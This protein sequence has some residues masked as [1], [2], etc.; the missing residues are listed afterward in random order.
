MNIT[1]YNFIYF[2]VKLYYFCP[3]LN[4]QWFKQILNDCKT[5]S[6]D[7]STTY[8]DDMLKLRRIARVFSKI[9]NL[10]CKA[11]ENEGEGFDYDYDEEEEEEEEAN[12]EE[13][14]TLKDLMNINFPNQTI[15]ID[16][17]DKN[18]G[19]YNVKAISFIRRDYT[20]F[21]SRYSFSMN[22]FT[23]PVSSGGKNKKRK[24]KKLRNK[25]KKD[26]L[27]EIRIN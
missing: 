27:E 15:N 9:F 11:I 20:K 1:K 6:E 4:L 2:Y 8:Y 26:E 21:K 25:N 18:L 22:I 17:D 24:T 10:E 13:D 7:K 14:P 3:I 23:P 12:P 5:L 19:F 16:E